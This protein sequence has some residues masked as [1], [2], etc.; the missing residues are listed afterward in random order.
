[1]T[2]SNLEKL[3]QAVRMRFVDPRA[4]AAGCA[5]IYGGANAKTQREIEQV[6]RLNCLLP[7]HAHMVTGCVV[8]L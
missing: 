1:M 2:K 4:A 6:M 5:A 8:V 3:E 7:Q